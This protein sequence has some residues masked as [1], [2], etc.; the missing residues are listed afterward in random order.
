MS[1]PCT[2]HR[3]HAEP[4]CRDCSFVYGFNACQKCHMEDDRCDHRTSQEDAIA[5]MYVD[6]MPRF[7]QSNSVNRYSMYLIVKAALD[8]KLPENQHE[9]S[10]RQPKRRG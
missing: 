10:P 9:Y 8:R 3:A 4:G 5:L 1:G 7:N 2:V 6:F